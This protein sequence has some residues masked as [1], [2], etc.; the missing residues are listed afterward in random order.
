MSDKNIDIDEEPAL[1]MIKKGSVY[2]ITK[3]ESDSFFE[4]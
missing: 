3:K 2:E 4:Q 1:L